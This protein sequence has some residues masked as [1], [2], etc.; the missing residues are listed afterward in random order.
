[1]RVFSAALLT[2]PSLIP[3]EREQGGRPIIHWSE[4]GMM[5]ASMS[6]KADVAAMCVHQSCLEL[7]QKTQRV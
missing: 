4:I 5:L 7:E 3:K 2:K 1:M 6:I